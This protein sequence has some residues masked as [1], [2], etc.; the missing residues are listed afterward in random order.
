MSVMGGVIE[1]YYIYYIYPS[2]HPLHQYIRLHLNNNTW[3]N[4]ICKAQA[5]MSKNMSEANVEIICE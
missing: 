5:T 4:G 2:L 1:G 3:C